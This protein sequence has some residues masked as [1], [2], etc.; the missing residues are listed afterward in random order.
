MTK[1]RHI[2]ALLLLFFPALAYGQ[3]DKLEY[4]LLFGSNVVTFG[5]EDADGTVQKATNAIRFATGGFA[6]V[7]LSSVVGIQ[8]ELLVT[9][10]GADYEIDGA[11]SDFVK[12][13]YLE[14]PVSIR[15]DLPWAASLP[16]GGQ[17][18]GHLLGGPWMS[19]VLSAKIDH[20]DG[21]SADIKESVKNID[22]GIE[23]GLGLSAQPLWWGAL[24]LS[25][26]YVLGLHQIGDTGSRD[27][28]KTRTLSF[29]LGFRCCS[30]KATRNRD[31]P[32]VDSP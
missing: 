23:L 31:R 27:D 2:F 10:K 20:P 5:G 11:A 4:G 32:K 30:N 14:L 3:S 6:V 21:T 25:A 15:V 24:E 29:T 22:Y 26:R 28:I 1:Q 16:W 8:P 13:T 17:L 7:R 12:L 18:K 9:G 19:L